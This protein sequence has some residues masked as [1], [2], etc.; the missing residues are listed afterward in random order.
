MSLQGGSSLHFDEIQN[1]L[2]LVFSLDPSN[3]L[4]QLWINISEFLA[5]IILSRINAFL[6][7]LNKSPLSLIS[8]N[9]ISESNYPALHTWL[10]RATR[11]F[12]S[13]VSMLSIIPPQ[14]LQMVLY[15]YIDALFRVFWICLI[16]IFHYKYSLIKI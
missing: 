12:F 5:S 1:I 2:R 13:Y 15:C 6:N 11:N 9:R 3:K 10:F 14:H 7:A 4:R 8:A 16:L